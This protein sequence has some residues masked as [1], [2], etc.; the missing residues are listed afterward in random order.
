MEKA[1]VRNRPSV[2]RASYVSISACV[3]SRMLQRNARNTLWRSSISCWSEFFQTCGKN[4]ELLKS[5]LLTMLLNHLT[6][7]VPPLSTKQKHL[8]YWFPQFGAHLRQELGC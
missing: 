7:P 5:N 1:I 8:L 2:L 3:P 6:Q 4:M